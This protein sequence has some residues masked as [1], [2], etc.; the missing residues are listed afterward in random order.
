MRAL[1]PMHIGFSDREIRDTIAALVLVQMTS[2][3]ACQMLCRHGS[4]EIRMTVKG[5]DFTWLYA[6]L[7]TGEDRLVM[8]AS[9]SCGAAIFGADDM[10]TLQCQIGARVRERR[11]ITHRCE[12]A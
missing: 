6:V 5:I 4:Y 8:S 3:H 11:E 1:A 12:A 2:R 10:R 9:T 7:S